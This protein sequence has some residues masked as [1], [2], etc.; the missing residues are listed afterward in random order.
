[1]TD[2]L[3]V[4]CER[5]LPFHRLSSALITP[6]IYCPSWRKIINYQQIVFPNKAA[7]A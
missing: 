1:M 7:V 2:T 4:L 3:C 5:S 6:D